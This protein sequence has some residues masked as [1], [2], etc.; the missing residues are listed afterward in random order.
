MVISDQLQCEPPALQVNTSPVSKGWDEGLG[1][2]PSKPPSST[3]LINIINFSLTLN[4]PISIY[5][6]LFLISENSLLAS[7][8]CHQQ[9]LRIAL[10]SLS[11]LTHFVLT[12]VSEIKSSRKGTSQEHQSPSPSCSQTLGTLFPVLTLFHLLAT[13]SKDDLALAIPETLSP[14]LCITPSCLPLPFWV[15]LS[16]LFLTSTSGS[17]WDLSSL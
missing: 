10:S 4:L 6:P 13:S 9:N 11:S 3:F 2:A 1:H 16:L 8:Y 14:G 12:I 7:S 17:S 15:P 5:A